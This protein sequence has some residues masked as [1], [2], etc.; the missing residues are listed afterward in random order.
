MASQ[1]LLAPIIFFEQLTQAIVRQSIDTMI[2]ATG[3]GVVVDQCI[4]DSFLRSLHDAREKRIHE[5]IGNCLHV[6]GD[7][8]WIRDV[9]VRS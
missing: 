7:L 9:R 4:R 6:M 3:H 8:I 5:I 2:V 1:G